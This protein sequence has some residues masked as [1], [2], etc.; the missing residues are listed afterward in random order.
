MSYQSKEINFHVGSALPSELSE[1]IFSVFRQ[2]WQVLFLLSSILNYQGSSYP[3]STVYIAYTYMYDI[4]FII[5]LNLFTL[6]FAET[7]RE[8]EIR[9]RARTFSK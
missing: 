8:K 5:Y 6:Y 2:D 7:K 3:G 1:A 4:M 9:K